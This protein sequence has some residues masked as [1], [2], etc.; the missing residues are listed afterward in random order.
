[1]LTEYVEAAMKR[2][3]YKILNDDEG[4]FGEIPACRGVWSNAKTLERCRLELRQVLE[5]WILIR[6][7]HGL[8]LP[9]VAAINLNERRARK[10]KVA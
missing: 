1:M 2:A 3:K 6:V 4:F 5:D 9:I 7:R 10:R 8:S